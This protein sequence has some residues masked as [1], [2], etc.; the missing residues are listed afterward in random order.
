MQIPTEYESTF[1]NVDSEAPEQE[2][3]NHIEY[4]NIWEQVTDIV[5]QARDGDQDD[6]TLERTYSILNETYR[7]TFELLKTRSTILERKKKCINR[8][9][10]DANHMIYLVPRSPVGYL[11]AGRIYIDY[12]YQ[13]RA[14]IL[15]SRGLQ[16]VPQTDEHYDLLTQGK[17]EALSRAK[18]RFDILS[19]LPLD[20]RHEIIDNYFSRK[21]L[22]QFTRVC[23]SWR[24]MIINYSKLWK[25]ILAVEWNDK[26]KE[27]EIPV[28]TLLPSIS[29]H[30]Q[31][32]ELPQ[33]TKTSTYMNNIPTTPLPPPISYVRFIP[34]FV[35]VAQSLTSLD[36]SFSRKAYEVPLFSDILMN[37]PNLTTLRYDVQQRVYQPLVLFPITISSPTRLKR[38]AIQSDREKINDIELQKL[39][40]NSPD[41]RCLS[42]GNCDDSVY[43]TIGKYGHN[44]KELNI[45]QSAE[46]PMSLGSDEYCSD[47]TVGLKHFSASGFDSPSCLLPMIKENHI[48]LRTL[49]L[50]LKFKSITA[51]GWSSLF[52]SYP[53]SNLIHL[54]IHD[55]DNYDL[56]LDESN[57]LGDFQFENHISICKTILPIMMV[58]N[59]MP[60]LQTLFLSHVAPIPDSV[61]DTFKDLPNLSQ[62]VLDGCNFNSRKMKE[63][64]ELCGEKSKTNKSLEKLVISD[65]P[66][67]IN[68]DIVY[69]ASKIQ[70]LTWLDFNYMHGEEELAKNLVPNIVKLPLLEHIKIS[71]MDMEL[72]DLFALRNC[73]LLRYIELDKN[74]WITPENIKQ[75]A[76]PSHVEVVYQQVFN[77]FL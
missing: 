52:T 72:R 30:I 15:F 41:L 37:L 47:D 21:E 24:K 14:F 5:E 50:R 59:K 18:K 33:N 51:P 54:N 73:S 16:L 8:Q 3:T 46:E 31:E 75:V 77:R 74:Y 20:I 69:A 44:I 35:S 40:T 32:L 64:L 9:L 25:Q 76:F 48:T 66:M 58:M 17:N 19:R 45:D 28:H 34:S 1:N 38:V 2:V 67:N 57:E 42:I 23:S 49:T 43:E 65:Q 12:G 10:N 70:S 55:F 62:L 60:H 63:F 53:L 29:Q 61:V 4:N 71:H 11:R 39:L 6:A 36:I 7:I 13:Q 26:P 56:T 27:G 22:T 68:H